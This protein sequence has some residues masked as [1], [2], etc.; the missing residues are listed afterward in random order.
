M[1]LNLLTLHGVNAWYQ[2]LVIGT[3]L[4]AAV[5]AAAVLQRRGA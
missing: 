4:I 1:H 2:D 5:A 3:V